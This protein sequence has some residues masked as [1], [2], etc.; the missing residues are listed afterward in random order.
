MYGFSGYATNEYGSRRF[1][2]LTGPLVEIA[3]RVLQNGYNVVNTLTS[4]LKTIVLT[5]TYGIMN[6]LML[7]F[8]GTTLTNPSTNNNSLEL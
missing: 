7:R 3:N 5:S 6:S 8:R 2:G 1:F 4:G